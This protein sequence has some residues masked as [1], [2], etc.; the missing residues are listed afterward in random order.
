M[1]DQLWA[2]HMGKKCGAIGNVRGTT[3]EPL[4]NLTGTHRE[5]DGNKA[6]KQKNLPPLPTK[7]INGTLM[8]PC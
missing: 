6:K 2:N 8:S 4:G 5:H 1:R 7:K 3:W